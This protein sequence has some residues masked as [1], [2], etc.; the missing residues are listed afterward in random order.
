MKDIIASVK[1][2]LTFL[3]VLFF[4]FSYY[5][6]IFHNLCPY[7]PTGV[8]G[9]YKYDI[10]RK[11]IILIDSIPLTNPPYIHTYICKYTYT[12]VRMCPDLKES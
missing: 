12:Y 9:K 1:P 3:L 11:A 8:N 7:A 2:M 5:I 6:R 4:Q 10:F